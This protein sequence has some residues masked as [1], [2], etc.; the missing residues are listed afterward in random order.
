M[1]KCCCLCS[2]WRDGPLTSLATSVSCLYFTLLWPQHHLPNCP[3]LH[4]C[5]HEHYI[6]TVTISLVYR[7][8]C[9]YLK[10]NIIQ[11]LD[12]QQKLYVDLM[13]NVFISIGPVWPCYLVDYTG[14]SKEDLVPLC[15]L[16]YVKW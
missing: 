1:E 10:C 14:F 16:L 5:S 9:N 4:Y 11:L 7:T 12:T 6:T 2:P 15:V 13:A 8:Y 3:V